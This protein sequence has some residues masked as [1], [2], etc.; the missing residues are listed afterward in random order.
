MKKLM[1]CLMGLILAL[2]SVFAQAPVSKQ[3]T[4]IETVSPTEVLIEATG[5]YISAEKSAKA[6]LKDV[7]TNGIARAIE[8]AKRAA[9]WLL[10]QG[11][12]DP[13]LRTK[14]EV[15]LFEV[16][17]SQFY[18]TESLSRYVTYEDQ[19]FI[20]RI[21]L[22]EGH[23]VKITKRFRLN[24]E[25]LLKDLDAYGV[26]SGRQELS[27]ALGRPQLMVLPQ[28]GK[29]QSPLDFLRTDPIARHAATVIE[30]HL[31][32]KQ[33]EV[34]AAQQIEQI[35][36]LAGLQGMIS[37]QEDDISYQLAV[38][39]GSD[40][41]I[42]YSGAWEST[43]YNTKRY[44][45]TV[46]AYETTSA[47][48]LGSET[49]YGQSRQGESMISVEEAMAGAID[50]VLSR[51][52]SYWRDDLKR[53]VQYKLI[54]GFDSSLSEDDVFDLQDLI[55]DNLKKMCSTTKENVSTGL[56]LE[57]QIWVDP[58]RYDSTRNLYRDLRNSFNE[59][60]WGAQMSSVNLNRKLLQLSVQ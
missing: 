48:L 6:K 2:A 45:M 12:T 57:M 33:F 21:S 26:I 28:M 19:K 29:G 34:L 36:T 38:S 25:L 3:A 49:G 41:Y 7:E 31:T 51:V 24:K 23:G 53:G 37:G 56:T 54:I 16:R 58:A 4:L 52:E 47:R 15:N 40:I 18:N 20:S 27:E 17:S 5:I 55:I 50:A 42:T 43:G 13:F 44:S 39:I 10:V 46:Q 11:G 22:E 59:A 14:E 35:G 9:V 8:D 60:S 32:A 1:L 30:S